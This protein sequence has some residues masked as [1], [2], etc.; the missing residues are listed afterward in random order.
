[1]LNLTLEQSWGAVDLFYLPLFRERTFPDADARLRGPFP[2]HGTPDFWSISGDASYE[3]RLRQA[4]PD[5]AVRYSH[6]LGEFDIGIAHFRGTSREPRFR[7]EGTPMSPALRPRYD[8][9]NQTSLD[10]QWTRDAW[11]WKLEALG[12]QGHGD[13][14]GATVAGFEYTLFQLFESPADL[15]LLAEFLYDGRDATAPVTPFDNDLFL[16]TRLAFNDVQDS[17]LLAGTIIDVLDGTT[18]MRVEAERRLGD[19]W[20]IEATAQFVVNAAATNPLAAVERDDFIQIRLT[21]FY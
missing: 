10:L 4:H 12:R 9:I 19:S 6:T 2:V 8:V 7:I 3:S 11:L 1:M 18:S 13:Y 5:F 14:F 17:S 16:G 15:G 20:K 21:W